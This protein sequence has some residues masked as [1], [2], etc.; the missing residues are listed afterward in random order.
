MISN[1]IQLQMDY[2]FGDPDRAAD[3]ILAM[4]DGGESTPD[5]IA[6]CITRAEDLG[7][8]VRTALA[9]KMLARQ[10]CYD[11]F[12]NHSPVRVSGR[13]FRMPIAHVVPA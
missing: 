11:N 1:C 13:P 8:D 2:L 12:R 5:D 6:R 9:K 3:C 10:Q 7:V 4:I